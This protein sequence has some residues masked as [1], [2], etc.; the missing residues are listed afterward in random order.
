M[1]SDA[2][3]PEDLQ[4]SPSRLLLLAGTLSFAG[5]AFFVGAALQY[6]G[7]PPARGDLLL[8]WVGAGAVVGVLFA[9]A[10]AK[11]SAQESETER[12]WNAFAQERGWTYLREAPL[13]DDTPLL[14]EG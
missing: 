5:G 1:A 2:P 4:T 10:A 13:R 14:R 3:A 6:V 11:S 8:L 9:F 7:A 12:Y